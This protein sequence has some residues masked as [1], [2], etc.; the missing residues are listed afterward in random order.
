MC[1]VGVSFGMDMFWL[2]SRCFSSFIIGIIV[3]ECGCHVLCDGLGCVDLFWIG[4]PRL[5]V[6]LLVS[7]KYVKC[8]IIRTIGK[9][10]MV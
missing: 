3:D 7:I 6:A 5:V 4:S 10:S 9:L 1:L 8:S 2:K